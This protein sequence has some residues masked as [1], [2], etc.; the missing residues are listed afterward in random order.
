MRHAAGLQ[1]ARRGGDR[2][3]DPRSRAELL[4][5]RL[6]AWGRFQHSPGRERRRHGRGRSWQCHRHWSRGVP[7][8]RAG[9][10]AGLG[11]LTGGSNSTASGVNA[12]GT[13]VVGSGGS[14]QS[15]EEFR[16]TQAGSMV[17]LGFLT[18]GNFS[19]ASGVNADGT[20]VVGAAGGEAFRWTQAGGMVGLGFRPGGT[21]SGASGVDADGTVVIGAADIPGIPDILGPPVEPFRWTPAGGLAGLGR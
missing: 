3:I 8:D 19:G 1:R 21:F 18:G 6:A 17:G 13:V 7:L 2:P 11:F 10:M 12:D 4:G 5:P 20:V 9:G 15:S 14:G 16:W